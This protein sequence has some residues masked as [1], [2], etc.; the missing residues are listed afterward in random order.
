[1]SF[2]VL[3]YRRME[4]FV[5]YGYSYFETRPKSYGPVP[6]EE[7]YELGDD[8]V[9]AFMN[10]TESMGWSANDSQCQPGQ[11]CDTDTRKKAGSEYQKHLY[12]LVI[13]L[14]DTFFSPV[15]ATLPQ[16]LDAIE[17]VAEYG[18]RYS[19]YQRSI[20]SVEWLE[21]RVDQPPPTA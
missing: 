8:L 18:V 20:R 11:L 3:Y 16:D 21:E 10:L 9:E 12:E 4:L 19:A 2:G 14:K 15:L 17:M 7:H 13:S 6:H 1:M 5:D